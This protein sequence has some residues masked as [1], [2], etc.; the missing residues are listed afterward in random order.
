MTPRP[1][2][3]LRRCHN[4]EDVR[5]LAGRRLPRP[6]FDYLEG[7]ADDERA[8]RDNLEAFA[9]RRLTPRYLV[10][11]SRIDTRVTVLGQPLEWPV[12]V[13]PTGMSRLFHPGGELAVARAA[14]D[15]GT[16][17]CLSTMGSRS[18]E[19]VAESARG[20]KAFQIYAFRD[21]GL[22]KEFI[23]RARAAK[24]G[25]LILT[26]DVPVGGNRE[27]DLRSGMTLPPKLGLMA[28]LEVLRCWPWA[29][30]YARAEPLRLANVAHRV[31]EASSGE[32]STLAAYIAN[33]F[34]PSVTWRDVE[35][36]AKAWGGPFAIKGLL[37]PD[38]ALRAADA[39]ATAVI[40]S[41]HGGRQ[42]ERAI[43]PL[44]ALPAIVAAIG[45]RLEVLMDGGVRRGVDVLTALS[46]G[47]RACLL[48]RPCLYGLA[49]GGTA[50]VAHILS[51]LRTEFVRGMALLGAS[52][53][54]AIPHGG[55]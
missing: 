35:W 8:L 37:A 9:R 48:G 39:G 28:W 50:G 38:D 11:V 4:V 36:I 25:A 14:A 51:V 32:V 12:V 2:A 24:Y 43:A 29:L 52:D 23:E 18:I 22:T 49:A 15:A 17:Y 27:R 21:R 41:N 1:P 42:L 47:A 30:R 6:I 55:G 7:G 46:L 33:Q 54:R 31:S 40:V 20:P 3:A 19:A 53:I 5:R 13:G 45:D 10:D 44:D 34:D 16:M 26:V